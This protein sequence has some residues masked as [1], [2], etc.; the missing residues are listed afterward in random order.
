V[1]FGGGL[2]APDAL[3][4]LQVAPDPESV[5]RLSRPRIRAALKRAHRRDIE[6]KTLTIQAVLRAPQ[7]GQ[8]DIVAQAHAATTRATVAVP[9]TLAGADR[10]FAGRGGGVFG[11]HPDPTAW[12]QTPGM[13]KSRLNRLARN[14]DPH[15]TRVS[16]QPRHGPSTVSDRGSSQQYSQE[17]TEKNVSVGPYSAGSSENLTWI[18]LSLYA[19]ARAEDHVLCMTVPNADNA[20]LS[21]SDCAEKASHK[22]R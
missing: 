11:R 1:S 19:E 6:A 10:D 21:C 5:A 14:R 15:H 9:V 17:S 7:L 3:G 18:F 20:V 12:P 16:R 13:S 4:L 2:A 8:P 22:C